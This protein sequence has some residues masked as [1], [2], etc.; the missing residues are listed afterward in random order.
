MIEHF[1]LQ[2]MSGADQVAGDADVGFGGSGVSGGMVVGED[3]GVGSGGDGGAE[4]LAG[5]DEDL[6]EE[7]FG[8]G[9]DAEES[10]AGVQEKDLQAFD[11]SGK[12]I[13]AEQG[14]DGFGIVED[15]GFATE[16]LGEAAGEC[17]GGLQGDGLVASDA[18][19]DELR[20]RG[21]R[22]GFEASEALQEVVG[23]GD[24]GG[25]ADTGPEEDREEFGG[26][27][28]FGAAFCEAFAGAVGFVE[29]ADAIR[30]GHGCREKS[31]RRSAASR[32]GA[33]PI[34]GMRGA[35][36]LL[37]ASRVFSVG[38]WVRRDRRAFRVRAE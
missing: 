15:G 2:Q 5:M 3:D 12:G 7:A 32:R 20:P 14:G 38:V 21:A 16:F 26:P 24:C 28:G 13:V 23:D 10:T 17:E 19:S 8:D 33:E 37:R 9:L 29:V 4:D 35:D 18:V 36:R 11:R 25:S 34:R 27:E 30:L 22:D 1:D 6:V 31:W